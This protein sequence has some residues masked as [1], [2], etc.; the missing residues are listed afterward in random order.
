MVNYMKRTLFWPLKKVN[1]RFSSNSSL[2]SFKSWIGYRG[3]A[4][5]AFFWVEFWAF[6]VYLNTN[7]VSKDFFP[8]H[9]ISFVHTNSSKTRIYFHSLTPKL[10]LKNISFWLTIRK[11]VVEVFLLLWEIWDGKFSLWESITFYFWIRDL[12]LKSKSFNMSSV[13]WDPRCQWPESSSLAEQNFLYSPQKI[14]VFLLQ[15]D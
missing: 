1:I 15:K 3:I 7:Q 6:L 4:L 2:L 10:S 11:K 13:G 5:A 12:N 9:A 8:F 14:R